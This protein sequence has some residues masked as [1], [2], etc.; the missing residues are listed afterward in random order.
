MKWFWFGNWIRIGIQWL[1]WKFG[2]FVRFHEFRIQTG[3]RS[4]S[5]H[6]LAWCLFVGIWWKFRKY[7][8]FGRFG[9]LGRLGRLG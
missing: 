1:V 5:W 6:Q 8:R 3:Q 4:R 2:F 9:R 7:S